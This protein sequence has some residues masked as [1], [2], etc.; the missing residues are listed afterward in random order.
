MST[1]RSKSVMTIFILLIVLAVLS[2]ISSVTQFGGFG[3]G[4]ARPQGGFNNGAGAPDGTTTG[5]GF[6]GGGG[7]GG[8][9]FQGGGGAGGG[10]FQGGGG[11]GGGGNF[12]GGGGGGGF[13]GGGFGGRGGGGFSLFTVTRSLGLSPQYIIYFNLA[14]SVIGILLALWCAFGVWTQKRWALNLAMLIGILFLLGALPGL[15]GLFSGGARFNLLRSAIPVLD[16]I[17]GAVIV[18]LGILPSVRD[19]FSQPVVRS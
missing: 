8:G 19:S 14:V 11:A 13:G 16:V 17:A 2:I 10:G 15:F 7:A 6:Q 9:G 5:G 3:F 1:T 4:R 18:F 12:Q